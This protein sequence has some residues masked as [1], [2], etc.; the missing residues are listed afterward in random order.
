MTDLAKKIAAD[1]IRQKIAAEEAIGVEREEISRLE[2]RLSG[3][4]KMLKSCSNELIRTET[5]LDKLE[6]AQQWQPI[7][8]A[9]ENKNV[10]VFSAPAGEGH[11]AFFDKGR[12]W[13]M[14]GRNHLNPTT[15]I[16]KVTHWMP[17]PEKPTD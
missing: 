14:D 7:E 3:S 12:W 2:I 16:T 4:R 11:E 1:A 17:L 8:T 10:L 15:F 5:R 9:P 13:V 6:A